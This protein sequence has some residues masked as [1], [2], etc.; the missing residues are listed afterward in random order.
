MLYDGF[1]FFNEFELL[2]IR[3]NELDG[4]VDRHVLVESSITFSGK[5]K[6]LYFWERHAEFEKYRHKINYVAVLNT[7][8]TT[9]PWERETFQRNAIMR[10]V[11]GSDDDLLICSDVDE[12]PRAS[13]IRAAMPITEM[14]NIH[15]KS[16]SMYINAHSGPW[17]HATIGPMIEFRKVGPHA[18][19]MGNY[20]KIENGGW[21]FSSIG[22]A[23]RVV[24]KLD[25]FSHQEESIQAFKDRAAIQEKLDKGLGL[26]GGVMCL[27]K[28]DGTFPEHL[29]RNKERFHYLIAPDRLMG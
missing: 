23:D 2:E 25:S 11:N 21:H 9:D 13:A 24:T 14:R 18:I 6:P 15:M 3:L 10:G 20:P 27:E 28:L 29:V 16:Y 19:R 1:L 22:G 7:P 4:L 5:P 12:I 8:E 17:Y 26:Y